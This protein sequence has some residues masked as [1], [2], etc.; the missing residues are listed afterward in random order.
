DKRH[1]SPQIAVRSPTAVKQHIAGKEYYASKKPGPQ[2]HSDCSG[3]HG[4][5]RVSG[6]LYPFER[7]LPKGPISWCREFLKSAAVKHFVSQMRDI[8][9]DEKRPT[10][11]KTGNVRDNLRELCPEEC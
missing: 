7:I 2:H 1:H 9:P 11:L 8:I 6:S 10:A 5:R 3:T 4:F